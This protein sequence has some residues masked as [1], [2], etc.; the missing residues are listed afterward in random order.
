MHTAR[1]RAKAVLESRL[2]Q[3]QLALVQLLILVQLLY[4]STVVSV[5]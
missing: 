5:Q 1:T 2:V 3:K 4:S